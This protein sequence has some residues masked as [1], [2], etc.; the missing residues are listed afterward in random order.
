M[1]LGVF[2][3]LFSDRTLDE[4]LSYLRSLG[5]EMIEIGC[6][7]YPGNAHA[8]PD[9]LLNDPAQLEAFKETV[10]KYGMEIS[11]LSCHGNPVHPNKETAAGYDKVIHDTILLA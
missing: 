6:G 5:V 8:N 4:T 10:A 3:T 1:K 7:G 11:A 2:T 9:I